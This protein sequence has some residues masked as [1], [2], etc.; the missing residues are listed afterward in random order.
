MLSF[1]MLQWHLSE[2][3]MYPQLMF[4]HNQHHFSSSCKVYT[5]ERHDGKEDLENS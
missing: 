3:L 5:T 2:V 4:L 1:W